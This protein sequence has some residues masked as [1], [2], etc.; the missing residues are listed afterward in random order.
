MSDKATLTDIAQKAG[1]SIGTVHR[2]LY[3]KPGVS[4]VVRQRILSIAQEMGY[5]SNHI[6]SSLRKSSIHIIIAF[7]RATRAARYFYSALWDGYRECNE[8]LNSYNVHVIEAPYEEEER[9][10]FSASI[11][12]A[13]IRNY[14]KID[15]IIV[16]GRMTPED[17][18]TIRLLTT[19]NPSIPVVAV[20]EIFDDLDCLCTIQSDHEMDGQMGADLLLSQMPDGGDIL[21]LPGER[22][23]ASNV[24]NA[25]AFEEYIHQYA[26]ASQIYRVYG[27]SNAVDLSAQVLETLREH[28]SIRGMY[29]VSARGTRYLISAARHLAPEARIPIVGSD[30]YEESAEALEDEILRFV[31]YKNPGNQARVGIQMMMNYLIWG[32]RPEQKDT[33]LTSL[34]V[35][36][37]NVGRYYP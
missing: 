31:I 28:D 1:V 9:G 6:A 4:D 36:R 13:M 17:M 25:S 20:G 15:A 37:S 12:R 16:G 29:S 2:A 24:M 5:K 22:E 11:G 21:I 18:E 35:S 19:E 7:P 27:A 23:R 33:R 32:N 8:L 14:Q 10:S 34:I 3:N 26:P 30:L